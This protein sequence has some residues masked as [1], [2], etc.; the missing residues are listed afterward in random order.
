M[1][2]PAFDLELD[3]TAGLASVRLGSFV[4]ET[5]VPYLRNVLYPVVSAGRAVSVDLDDVRFVD[6]AGLGALLYLKEL[7]EQRGT[8]L[9]FRRMPPTV[10][11]ALVDL[12]L[13]ESFA[14]S[15]R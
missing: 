6:S 4:D 8:L 2:T 5:A 15:D 9:E 3:G 14:S 7:A 10:G 11:A 12:A 1:R 13:A